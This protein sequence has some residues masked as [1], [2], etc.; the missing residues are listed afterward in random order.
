MATANTTDD[1]IKL[2]DLKVDD[3][4]STVKSEKEVKP[5]TEKAKQ[6]KPSTTVEELDFNRTLEEV[7]KALKQWATT[8]TTYNKIPSDVKNHVFTVCEQCSTFGKFNWF[9]V[10]CRCFWTVKKTE[11][12]EFDLS[13]K[14]SFRYCWLRNYNTLS[15]CGTDEYGTAT[16]TKALDEKCTPRQICDKYFDLHTKIYQWFQLD[17]DYFGRTSTE[18]QT[19]FVFIEIEKDFNHLNI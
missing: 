2:Q 7:T 5:K 3:S 4:S 12:R 8:P 15:L 11:T 16:E 9:I 17:F 19:A 13:I 18:K 1:D 14:I 6:K 10:E